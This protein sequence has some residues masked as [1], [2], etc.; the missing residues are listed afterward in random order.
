MGADAARFWQAAEGARLGYTWRPG[1]GGD[2]AFYLFPAAGI[3]NSNY[4]GGRRT[5]R[6]ATFNA[7]TLAPVVSLNVGYT[8]GRP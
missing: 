7:D 8:L 1:R 3:Y 4:V 6:G 2:G 5:V